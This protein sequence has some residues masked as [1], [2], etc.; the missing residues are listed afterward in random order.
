LLGTSALVR[1]DR[2]AKI[3]QGKVLATT[4]GQ[5]RKPPPVAVVKPKVAHVGQEELAAQG[6]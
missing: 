3:I 1:V 5:A 2:S 4:A 6:V